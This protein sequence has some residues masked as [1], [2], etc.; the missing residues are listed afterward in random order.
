MIVKNG[1]VV[2]NK[3]VTLTADRVIHEDFVDPTTT[4]ANATFY[5]VEPPYPFHGGWYTYDGANF[6]LTAEGL[7]S[8]KDDLVHRAKKQRLRVELDGVEYMSAPL[9]TDKETQSRIVSTYNGSVLVPGIEVG[10]KFADNTWQSLDA[11][12]I[13]NMFLT[14]MQHVETCFGREAELVAAANACTDLAECQAVLDDIHT[15]WPATLGLG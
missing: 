5:E 7:E 3:D 4:T 10:W 9:P 12:A 8:F 2:Y 15:G 11:T 6:G 13:A 14:V 1:V